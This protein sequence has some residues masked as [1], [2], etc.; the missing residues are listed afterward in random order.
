LLGRYDTEYGL[1]VL[2]D[3]FAQERED[4]DV[5][6]RLVEVP[7]EWEQLELECQDCDIT[8]EELIADEED[9]S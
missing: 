7:A 4:A 6:F 8:F 3:K 9:I 2:C 5:L 1:K